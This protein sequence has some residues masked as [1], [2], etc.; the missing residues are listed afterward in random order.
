MFSRGTGSKI[1]FKKKLKLAAIQ[2]DVVLTQEAEVAVVD[3]ESKVS[4][5]AVEG[6]D[7]ALRVRRH[8][9]EE[10]TFVAFQGFDPLFLHL[11][12]ELHLMECNNVRLALAW[13]LFIHPILTSYFATVNNAWHP[14]LI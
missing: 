2:P 13:L 6:N 8:P 9:L 5:V 7:L 14:I 11:P 12:G 1:H 3:V 4:I 10:D